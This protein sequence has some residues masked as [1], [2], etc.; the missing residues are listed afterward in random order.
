MARVKEGQSTRL[1]PSAMDGSFPLRHLSRSL[2]P[3]AVMSCQGDGS[4]GR[5]VGA[6]AWGA[7]PDHSVRKA[8]LTVRSSD[9]GAPEAPD[10]D[11]KG[12]GS[13]GSR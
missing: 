11:G 5:R 7:D 10:G 1:M 3:V 12:A 13:Q 2:W 6:E 4:Q 8:E 9:L